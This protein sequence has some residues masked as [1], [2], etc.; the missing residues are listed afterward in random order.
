[1]K[2]ALYSNFPFWEN[3]MVPFETELDTSKF[4]NFLFPFNVKEGFDFSS[5]KYWSR[6]PAKKQE[7][8]NIK[9]SIKLQKSQFLENKKLIEDQ[10]KENEEIIS[11]K[12]ASNS[13]H[14]KARKKLTELYRKRLE[15]ENETTKNKQ[16]ILQTLERQ[17]KS[18]FSK[19]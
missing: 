14:E 9:R 10:I 1:M 4:C 13:D 2:Y 15:F 6:G 12:V 16:K 5:K 18:I 11:K 8:E 17:E 7:I 3:M 19:A